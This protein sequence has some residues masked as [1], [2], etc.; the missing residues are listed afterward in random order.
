MHLRQGQCLCAQLRWDWSYFAGIRWIQQLGAAPANDVTMVIQFYQ[1]VESFPI[2]RLRMVGINGRRTVFIP[3]KLCVTPLS[4]SPL[5]VF[6]TNAQKNIFFRRRISFS[7][8]SCHCLFRVF[9]STISSFAS[10]SCNPRGSV[11]ENMETRERVESSLDVSDGWIVWTSD[12]WNRAVLFSWIVQWKSR[13]WQVSG[14][15]SVEGEWISF[16]FLACFL[17][18]SPDTS[19]RVRTYTTWFHI[20]QSGNSETTIIFYLKN[21]CSL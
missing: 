14:I 6:E 16:A 1:L 18:G 11:G 12:D 8:V 3:S 20:R 19:D 15:H 2:L 7:F 17:R 10:L 21:D 5:F 13:R 4:F 9:L